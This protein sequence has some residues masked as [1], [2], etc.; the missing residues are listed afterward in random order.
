[1]M[2]IIIARRHGKFSDQL[3]PRLRQD[4]GYSPFIG[5]VALQSG[6][7]IRKLGHRSCDRCRE[8]DHIGRRNAD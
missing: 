6:R 5:G 7:F 4:L 3:L 1:M 2:I 8:Q